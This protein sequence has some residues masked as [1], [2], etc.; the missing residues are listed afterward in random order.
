MKVKFVAGAV[1]MQKALFPNHLDVATS[2]VPVTICC[3][4]MAAMV[5]NKDLKY[6]RKTK[7]ISSKYNFVIDVLKEKEVLIEYISIGQ[8][9]AY[10][11]T[12]PTP[13]NIFANHVKAMS[14]RRL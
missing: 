11:L 13:P 10:S 2:Y 9:V 12:K 4:S 3:D 14:F 6:H 7:H 5:Y 1:A 8:M